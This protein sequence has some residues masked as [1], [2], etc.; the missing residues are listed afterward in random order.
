MRKLFIISRI[1]HLCFIVVCISS[2]SKDEVKSDYGVSNSMTLFKLDN[3]NNDVDLTAADTVASQAGVNGK[4]I[5][6]NG[7][8]G[9]T[10]GLESIKIDLLTTDNTLLNSVT[11]TSFFKPE[12]HVINTQLNIPA[13]ARG[14]VYNVVV[15]AT[16][17]EGTVL[18]TKQFYG[19][20]VVS[21]DPLPP[22]VVNN[23]IAVIVET[24]EGTPDEDLYIFGS[25][26]GWNRGDVTFKLNK[27]PD[28]PNCY[29][30]TIPFPPGY[31][32]WQ[33]GEVFVSRGL[34]E[35]DAVN[36]DGSAFIVMYTTTEMGPLW[37]IKV[38]KWRDQ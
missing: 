2:C 32:D 3:Q 25:I 14:R 6:V 37:K 8:V 9:A 21:C 36:L 22:C 11:I 29:C 27:N 23:Q 33:V 28:V 31:S 18:D 38:P 26:N 4:F 10:K 13:D 24:P 20:D 34:F 12:Y 1:I 17:K 35:N 7:A 16:D 5:P 30:V 19:V 15:T